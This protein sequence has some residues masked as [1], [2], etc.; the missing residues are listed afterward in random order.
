MEQV[1]KNIVQDIASA[2][3]RANV[4]ATAAPSA[5]TLHYNGRS[6]LVIGIEDMEETAAVAAAPSLALE[7]ARIGAIAPRPVFTT[8][9]CHVTS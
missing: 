2:N 6:V 7:T 4:S 5:S 8:F 9:A 1:H 3:K